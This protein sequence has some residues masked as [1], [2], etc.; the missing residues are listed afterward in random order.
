MK[1]YKINENCIL[2]LENDVL[3][4]LNNYCQGKGM[5]ERGGILLGKIRTDYSEYI[6]TNISEPCNKD[7]M[8]RHYFIRNKENAQNV[9]NE[10]WENSDGQVIYLG[11]WHT[12]PELLPSPSSVDIKLIKQCSIEV[13]HLPPYIFLIIV[14]EHG[15]LYVGSKEIN[16][17]DSLLLKLNE[18]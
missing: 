4:K 8:G 10:A 1:T 2:R 9:I 6:I 18:V 14:G 12:H 13:E 5:S 16:T 3:S 17:K 11:E 7:R 15:T